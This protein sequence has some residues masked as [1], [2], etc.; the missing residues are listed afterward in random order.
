MP[1]SAAAAA[2]SSCAAQGANTNSDETKSAMSA[3][4][5]LVPSSPTEPPK[6]QQS[7]SN[8]PWTPLATRHYTKATLVT[9]TSS[10]PFPTQY[11]PTATSATTKSSVG[12]YRA[13]V[14][15]NIRYSSNTYGTNAVDGTL[16]LTVRPAGWTLRAF[17]PSIRRLGAGTGGCVDLHRTAATSKVVAIKTL[18]SRPR[19]AEGTREAESQQAEKGD[20]SVLSRRV[21]EELG[22]AVNMRHRNI[23]STHEVIVE[24]DRTCY[25]VMEACVVDLLT[26]IQGRQQ[27]LLP[28]DCMLPPS[29]KSAM[30]GYF[31]QLV[32]GVHYLHSIGVGH[33]DLKLDNI[34]VTEQGVLKIVDFGCATLFRRRMQQQQQ[35]VDSKGNAG[36]GSS[37]S[38]RMAPRTRATP[39]SVPSSQRI[40]APRGSHGHQYVETMS[41]GMCGSDPYMAP[42]L[43][44]NGYYM[45]PKVDVWALGIIYFA[46]QNQQFPWSAAQASRDARYK[47]FEKSPAA[48]VA[49]WF[50]ATPTDDGGGLGSLGGWSLV[51][52]S[53]GVNFLNMTQKKCHS[54]DPHAALQ[55]ADGE[56]TPVGRLVR[57]MLDTNPTSRADI[58][59]IVDDPWF[60]S[61]CH[62]SDKQLE[63]A[64]AFTWSI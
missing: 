7:A 47:E 54:D 29:D 43:F 19:S 4:S 42:E 53:P 48:F 35:Q 25:V 21:L 40:D 2:A 62:Q 45:A 11:I 41:Y 59:E 38:A 50:S 15:R 36:H 49:T 57:R 14:S 6:A 37:S 56:R 17:G 23:I 1:S 22:I 9:T 33:R 63:A 30:D 8:Q 39:Y 64:L 60:K 12:S 5:I 16:S 32:R 61:M 26:L 10:S 27:K 28:N 34:C 51:P 24:T 52:S 58:N 13:T 44:S 55:A 3:P 31:V 46:I 20:N 18:Q